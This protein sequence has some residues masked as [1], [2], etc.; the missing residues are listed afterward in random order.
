MVS[1]RGHY[2]WNIVILCG[3]LL[4]F[5]F[6]SLMDISVILYMIMIALWMTVL[7]VFSRHSMVIRQSGKVNQILFVITFFCGTGYYIKAFKVV[8]AFM[9]DDMFIRISYGIVAYFLV[10]VIMVTVIMY[11]AC[12]MF[13]KQKYTE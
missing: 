10:F 4:L 13:R 9:S 8:F 11:L 2:I 7:L 5:S 6:L 1:R 3:M 12:L